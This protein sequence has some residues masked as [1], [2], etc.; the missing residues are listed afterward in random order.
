MTQ[1]VKDCRKVRELKIGLKTLI[2]AYHEKAK[3]DGE[4]PISNN[5]DC[6]AS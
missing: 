6:P 2:F 1:E 5:S 3:G 4:Y